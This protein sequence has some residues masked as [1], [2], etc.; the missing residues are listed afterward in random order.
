[1]DRSLRDRLWGV[2]TVALD[3]RAMHPLWRGPFR[4]LAKIM[5]A[6][7]RPRLTVVVVA[8]LFV[9]SLLA[10]GLAAPAGAPSCQGYTLTL[11]FNI[12]AGKAQIVFNGV[13][14]SNGQTAAICVVSGGSYSLSASN[15]AQGYSFYQW[16]TS[17]KGQ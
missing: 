14:Y 12:Y 13:T 8:T 3:S 1:M 15:I 4:N 16:F 17:T 11:T 2:S 9:G 6:R 5:G 7:P 10:L